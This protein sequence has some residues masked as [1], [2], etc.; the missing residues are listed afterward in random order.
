MEEQD[1]ARAAGKS[2]GGGRGGLSSLGSQ[3]NSDSQADEVVKLDVG[4]SYLQLES[5]LH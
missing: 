2:R 5:D 1:K 3:G 4:V